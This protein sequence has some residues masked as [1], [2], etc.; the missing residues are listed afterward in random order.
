MPRRVLLCLPVLLSFAAVLSA[1]PACD[2]KPYR[3]KA[4]IDAGM[5]TMT[6]A[7]AT[8]QDM[9]GWDTLAF[10]AK[11][12]FRCAARAGREHTMYSVTGW[13][14]RVKTQS[15]GDWH[16]EITETRAARADSCVVVEIP[17][18]EHNT[19]FAQA[20]RDFVRLAGI[21]VNPDGETRFSV[22]VRMRFVG[23]A[24]FDGEHRRK[25]PNRATG[26]NHGRCNTSLWELHPVVWV[27]RP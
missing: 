27:R 11:A 20:R 24:F 26:F 14:R 19:S 17:A 5:T 15:D 1:Q 12:R 25:A 8:V 4:K 22:P 3:W 6:P 10:D 16:I 23:P 2:G 7:K 9:L 21:A 18:P 13:V